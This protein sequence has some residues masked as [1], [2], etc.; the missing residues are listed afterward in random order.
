MLAPLVDIPL[1]PGRAAIAYVKLK[2]KLHH[3]ILEKVDLVSLES[4]TEAQLRHEIA[5]IVEYTRTVLGS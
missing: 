2:N 1:P 5:A 3:Q 4:M